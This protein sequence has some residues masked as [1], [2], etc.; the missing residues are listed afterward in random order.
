MAIEAQQVLQARLEAKRSGLLDIRSDLQHFAIVSYAL[1]VERL[2]P[3]IPARFEIPTFPIGGQ[4]LA[5]MSAVQFLDEDFRYHR[6]APFLRWRFGQTNYRVYVVDRERGEHC[7]W[8]FGT[9][10]GSRLVY[11]ARWLWRIP[12]HH[13]AYRLDC[14]YDWEAEAYAHY[15]V[16]H[17]SPWASAEIDLADSGEPAGLAEGF[18]SLEEQVLILTHP[19]EG[20]YHRLD[21][22]LGC[23]S[24]W[25]EPIPLTTGRHRRLYFSLYE[26][27]RLLTKKEMQHPHSVFLCPRIR[28]DVHLPPKLA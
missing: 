24:V 15:H 25:H 7:V 8:F 6:L 28:F 16:S 13:A 23:Y 3:H 9:T 14:R 1:P 27:L 26:R 12:W 10:I 20:F 22:K 2:R 19:V 17:R 11:P 21:G 5:L 18:D 4:Q